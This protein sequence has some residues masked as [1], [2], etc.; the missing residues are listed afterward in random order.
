MNSI[1]SISWADLLWS[2]VI[3]IAAFAIWWLIKRFRDEIISKLDGKADSI[4]KRKAAII[5]ASN[6]IKLLLITVTVLFVLQTNGI[7]VSSILTGLGIVGAAGALAVQDTAKDAIQGIRILTGDYYSVGDCI[8]YNGDD[9]QVIEFS[10]RTTVLKSI[11]SNNTVI[12]SNRNVTEVTK[13]SGMEFLYI[14]LSY[15]TNPALADK[16][17]TECAQEIG[18]VK[19]ISKS[20]YLGLREFEESSIQ[21]QLSFSCKPTER[22]GMRRAAMRIIKDNLDRNNI[23]LPYRKITVLQE[24]VEAED[25]QL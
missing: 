17:L 7:N 6:F 11:S 5:S 12:V 22:F 15:E 19:G 13:L 25:G 23:L 1:K 10:I 14:P 4:V 16:V 8:K 9:Y 21:Y 24:G 3:V 20:R 2:L 18:R